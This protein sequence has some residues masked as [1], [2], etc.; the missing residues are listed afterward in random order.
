MKFPRWS[1]LV[2]SVLAFICGIDSI[3]EAYLADSTYEIVGFAVMAMLFH[4]GA[5]LMFLI[6]RKSFKVDRAF[7]LQARVFILLC[8]GAVF[9]SMCLAI[10]LGIKGGVQ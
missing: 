1:K 5:Y 3:R 10:W 8:Y 4:F 2:L 6:A 7:K 9:C